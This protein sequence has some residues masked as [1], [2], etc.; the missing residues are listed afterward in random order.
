MLMTEAKPDILRE[1]LEG[2][3]QA[4]QAE[5]PGHERS[6]VEQAGSALDHV[7][8]ALHLHRAA[9]EAPEGLLTKVDLTRP[10]LVREVSALRREHTDTLEQ[11]RALQAR[12]RTAAQ[13][14]EPYAASV[15]SASPLPEPKPAAEVPDF[16]AI[17]QDAEQLLATLQ[18]HQEQEARLLLESVNTDIGVGD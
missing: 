7:E 10:T 6:W 12:L 9:A 14:F 18:H 11:V 1:S 16:N 13:A 15:A 5:F 3:Q 2:F 4:L 17:R 8:Q